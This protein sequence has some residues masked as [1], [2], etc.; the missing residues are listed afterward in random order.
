MSWMN[1]AGCQGSGE[2]TPQMWT[3][4][5]ALITE[6]GVPA[7]PRTYRQMQAL[8]RPSLTGYTFGMAWHWHAA[9]VQRLTSCL[10]RVVPCRA[11]VASLI[12]A[13]TPDDILRHHVPLLG[14]TPG[15][16]IM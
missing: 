13:L 7:S 8:A 3:R 2:E 1:S 14:I 11:S 9:C 5:L 6:K 10:N 4:Q 16:P 15:A 12:A